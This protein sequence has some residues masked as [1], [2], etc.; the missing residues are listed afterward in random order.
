MHYIYKIGISTAS[1]IVREV[2]RCI[3]SVMQLE[4][5]PI[6]T[7]DQW[8]E[9]ALEFERRAQSPH[10]LGAV[11][12]KHIRLMC[13]RD[14]G[15]MFFNYK[16]YF[17]LVLMAVA[18]SN[19]RFLYVGIGSFGKEC[20]STI[21]KSSSL[22]TAIE[23]SA[24]ILPTEKCLPGTESPKLPY[25]FIGDEAFGLHKHLLRPYGGSN[26]TVKKRVFNYRL[27]R[28]RTYVEC[29][30]GILSNKWRIFHRPI[31]VDPDFAVDIVMACV[32]LHNFVRDRDGYRVE[33]TM[34]ITGFED[35]PRAQVVRGGLAANNIRNVLSDY[36]LTNVGAVKWQMSK[37]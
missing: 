35:L 13:P 6:P 25:F 29:T 30:F 26:L 37:I 21:F 33:D 36:F 28:A 8:E 22:W 2:C 9:I 16:A 17:S 23:A 12:G 7:K 11:D 19:Y 10:C 14:S 3:A 27:C 1:K 24:Q 15:S 18:D 4:C 32:I 34:T 20:D 31:N 5:I